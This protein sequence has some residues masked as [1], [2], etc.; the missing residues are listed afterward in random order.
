MNNQTKI[1]RNVEIAPE[2]VDEMISLLTTFNRE[3][4]T[5][6]PHGPRIRKMIDEIQSAN[7]RED[8]HRWYTQNQTT[9]K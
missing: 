3:I 2:T 5:T 7:N 8:L 4:S 6:S 1:S 9:S